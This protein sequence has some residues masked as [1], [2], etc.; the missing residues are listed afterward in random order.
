MTNIKNVYLDYNAI[1]LKL[2]ALSPALKE[3]HFDAIVMVLRG[4]SFAG[5]HL[6]FLTGLPYYF[7]Q[8]DRTSNTV[9]WLGPEPERKKI[10][11]VEDFAGVGITLIDCKNFLL[12]SGF[13]VSTLVV[14]KDT[15]SASVP[16]YYCFDLQTDKARFI[17]PWERHILNHDTLET[18]RTK[19][20]PD[21]SYEK[22][23]WDLDGIYVNDVPKSLYDE[24]VEKALTVRSQLPMAEYAPIPQVGDVI[25]TG[26]IITDKV[27]TEEWLANNQLTLPLYV[28][29]YDIE[30][31]SNTINALWKGKKAIELGFTHYVESDAEQ[32]TLIASAYPELRVTWWNK[33][34]PVHIQASPI[35]KSVE[36]TV[37]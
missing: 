26:R 35:V 20:I 3:Q 27:R 8:Y 31:H 2:D 32:A 22:T 37:A 4:G 21:H 13:A 28:R 36:Q 9:S 5:F 14:C 34:N 24:D 33:G 10:L 23:A 7:L 15:K 1:S 6:A 30:N 25:I 29:E 16:D 17:L 19:N 11:L 18:D 12:D